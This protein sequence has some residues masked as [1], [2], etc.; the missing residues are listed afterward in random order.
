MSKIS[1]W[2]VAMLKAVVTHYAVVVISP[3]KAHISTLFFFFYFNSQL[4]NVC[5]C[6][7]M[8][9]DNHC[10][11]L[12]AVLLCQDVGPFAGVVHGYVQ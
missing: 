8:T 2:L 9:F 10:M 3:T 7:L 11:N 12:K 4:G 5:H 6:L 1:H